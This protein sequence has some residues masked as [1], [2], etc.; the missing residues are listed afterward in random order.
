MFQNTTRILH[1][2]VPSRSLTVPT[3]KKNERPLL[4]QF[5]T[6]RLESDLISLGRHF[7]ALAGQSDSASFCSVVTKRLDQV[8]CLPTNSTVANKNRTPHSDQDPV[9]H[10][11]HAPRK[12][13]RTSACSNFSD[14]ISR[15]KLQ[16]DTH[17]VDLGS[18][19]PHVKKNDFFC[20]V[21]SLCPSRTGSGR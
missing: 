14:S 5:H 7:T 4:F 16:F 1:R 19:D 18:W 17:S 3:P 10:H 15:I 21:L 6:R 9:Q 20:L 11:A 2:S 12:R 8:H 13:S